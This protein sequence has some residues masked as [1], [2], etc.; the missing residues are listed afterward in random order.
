M[1]KNEVKTENQ[2]TSDNEVT[3]F[4][5][6]VAGGFAGSISVVVGH[7]FDTYKVW[8]Q[9][10]SSSPNTSKFGGMMSIFRGITAPLSTAAVVNAIIFSSYGESSRL[11]DDLFFSSGMTPTNVEETKQ[12]HTSWQKSFICGSIAGAVQSLVVCPTE[13][14]KCRLQVQTGTPNLNVYKGSFDAIDKIVEKYGIRGLYR[15]YCC[16][17]WREIPAFGLYF[18]SY[19]FVKEKTFSLFCDHSELI[20]ENKNTSLKHDIPLT[21][22]ALA[23]GISGAFTWAVI[24]PFDV[25]KTRIQTAPLDASIE[26]RRITYLANQILKENGCRGLFRGLGVT[27]LRAFPVNGIIFPVYEFTLQQ[28]TLRGIGNVRADMSAVEA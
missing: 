13:H 3:A 11:W 25:I 15:G 16:T 9:T 7:P 4:Q 17:A 2:I 1:G 19:D 10:S 21:I 18:A 5:D 8:L 28:L 6:L 20:S 24:Y 23:G 12:D 27:L 22:S 26:Q 14:V